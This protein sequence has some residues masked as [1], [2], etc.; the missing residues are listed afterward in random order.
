[1]ISVRNLKLMP[2]PLASSIAFLK[3]SIDTDGEVES[4]HDSH[5]CL[6]S[7]RTCKITVVVASSPVNISVLSEL[8]IN[9]AP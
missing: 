1:V 5:L 6:E 4:I 2:L 7:E 3:T 9:K 8:G